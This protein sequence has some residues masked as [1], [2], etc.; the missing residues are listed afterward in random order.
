MNSPGTNCRVSIPYLHLFW[1]TAFAVVKAAPNA[2][3]LI[4]KI[5]PNETLSTKIQRVHLIKRQDR[6][7]NHFVVSYKTIW[8]TCGFQ[9]GK[10]TRHVAEYDF[11]LFF[12]HELADKIKS[13]DDCTS[14]MT[15]GRDIYECKYYHWGRLQIWGQKL[16]DP[17]FDRDLT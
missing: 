12:Q 13:I 4:L 15:D 5:I 14:T 11:L 3:T 10:A 7:K 17:H 8:T 16:Q 1:C 6:R 9:T 2:N